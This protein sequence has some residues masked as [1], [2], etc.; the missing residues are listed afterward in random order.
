MPNAS[1]R[2]LV[3]E[4]NFGLAHVLQ[5]NLEEKGFNVTVAHDGKEA[6]EFARRE[7]FD[8]V[9]TDHEMPK[10]T[11]VELCTHLR[12]MPEYAKTPLVMVTAREIELD[13]DDLTARLGFDAILPKPYS[14]DQLLK[15]VEKLL[16][17][18]V[19]PS[20]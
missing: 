1:K 2:V 18:E 14:P 20:P 3:A 13:C 17:E 12:E 15:M 4:D 9:L 6:L 16:A 7:Q 19:A 8:I 10:M 5:Y 11:G